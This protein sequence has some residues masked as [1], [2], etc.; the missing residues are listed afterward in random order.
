MRLRVRLESQLTQVIQGM[1][2]MQQNMTVIQ[3]NVTVIQE[4]MATKQDVVN[5]LHSFYNKFT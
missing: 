2:V 1:T 5:Y 4:K 3:Q